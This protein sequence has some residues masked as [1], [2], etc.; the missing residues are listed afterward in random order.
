MEHLN[1]L[2]RIL[3][4]AHLDEGK[5]PGPTCH[6]VLHDVDRHNNAGLREI[7][8]QVIFRRGEGEITDE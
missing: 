2:F 3:L 7:I 8:L 4:R 5:A 1:G 6:A